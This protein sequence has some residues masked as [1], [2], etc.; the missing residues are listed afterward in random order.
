MD[1]KKDIF[2]C[3]FCKKV[4]S[5]KQSLKLHIN[6]NKKCL[7]DRGIDLSTI[8]SFKCK[9]KGCIYSSFLK[10][11]M[12]KHL[13]TCKKKKEK[14]KKERKDNIIQDKL[15]SL[16]ETLSNKPS[17]IN[18][19]N[20]IINNL[21]PIPINE[22]YMKDQAQYLTIDHIKRGSIGYSDFILDHPLRD[23][24]VCTDFARRKVKYKDEDGDVITDPD[25]YNILCLLFTSIKEKNIEL[26]KQYVEELLEKIKVENKDYFELLL[27]KFTD[28]DIKFFEMLKGVKNE[29]YHEIVKLIC[30]KTIKI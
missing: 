21:R 19:T 9:N 20:T 2:S 30:T 28:Q 26:T 7:K 29:L 3:D 17:I 25:M 1:E 6:T 12:D 15:I 14:E 4:L 18:N 16:V 5:S 22:E 24:V 23:A 13:F 11:D 27:N 10:Q 8:E